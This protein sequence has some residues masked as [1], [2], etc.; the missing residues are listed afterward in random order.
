MQEVVTGM[1]ASPVNPAMRGGHEVQVVPAHAES[2]RVAAFDIARALALVAVIIGHTNGQGMPDSVLRFCYSFDMPLFFI[3]SGYFLKK[4]NTLNKVFIYKNIKGL[5]LPYVVTCIILVIILTIKSMITSGGIV[6]AS[7]VFYTWL[8]AGL[9]GAGGKFHGMPDGIESIGAIWYLLALFW[10]KLL[11]VMARQTP[12]PLAV[13]LGLFVF[14]IYSVEAT[15][16]PLSV[17]PACCAALFLFIGQELCERRIF[18]R[19][20][21]PIACWIV[22][23]AVWLFCARYYGQLYMVSNS[24]NGGLMDVIGGVCG[25]LCVIKF[26]DLL[27]CHLSSFSRVLQR[28]GSITLP[29]FCMH[30][31]ELRLLPWSRLNTILPSLPVPFWMSGLL[32][33]ISAIALFTFLLWL[34]PRFLSGVFFPSKRRSA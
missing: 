10:A 13:V 1:T 17:Q 11:V 24:Y 33:R 15:W 14:G 30:L 34:S 4:D 27:S 20:S 16:L 18:T 21:L 31:L 19:G 22:F 8:T 2:K 12:Y 6:Q 7:Q 25:S 5:L 28:F 32:V 9:Y 29:V 23:F 3:I 26:S